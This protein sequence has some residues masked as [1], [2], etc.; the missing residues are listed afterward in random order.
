MS[1]GRKSA[2][3]I[4]LESAGAVAAATARSVYDDGGLPIENDRRWTTTFALLVLASSIEKVVAIT[5]V[6]SESL[7][8]LSITGDP[9]ISTI[10]ASARQL[11]AV[12]ASAPASFL[13]SWV[14][15]RL[16]FIIGGAIGMSGCLLCAVALQT[17]SFVAL[18]FGTAMI[19]M[20]S[21]F[22]GYS[23][24]V[25]AQVVPAKHKTRAISLTIFSSVF[26]AIVGP[27]L[28]QYSTGLLPAQFTATFLI[29]G[30][31]AVLFMCLTA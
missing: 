22:G 24:Y 17:Q 27:R 5:C 3:T 20:E 13:M 15:R 30:S 2:R 10:P 1:Q 19:G 11:G 8:A 18:C 28:A 14:G 7:A 4:P 21:G 26:A 31:V 6:S 23:K 25:A 12:L 16:G 29:S 9:S